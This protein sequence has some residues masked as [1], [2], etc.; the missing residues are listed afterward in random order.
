MVQIEAIDNHTKTSVMNYIMHIVWNSFVKNS[1]RQTSLFVQEN[2][3]F[4]HERYM[5]SGI[6]KSQSRDNEFPTVTA[7][8]LVA[9]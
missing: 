6:Q 3:P 5:G 7:I 8:N 1:T 2:N 9:R 4:S